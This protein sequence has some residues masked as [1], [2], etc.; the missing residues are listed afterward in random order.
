MEFDFVAIIFEKQKYKIEWWN[1]W[2]G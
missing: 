2:S 1:W